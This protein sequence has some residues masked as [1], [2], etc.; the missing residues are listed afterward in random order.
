MKINTELT[1][2]RVYIR[3]Y[4]PADLDFAAGMWLDGENGRYLSDPA[5]DY[6]DEAF[7]KALDTLQ[8]S[9][10]GCYLTVCLN[11]TGERV[12]TCCL[13]PDECREGYDIGYCVHKSRWG[14][15]LAGE[16]VGL[17]VDEGILYKRRG[18]GM[19]VSKGAREKILSKRKAAFAENHVAPLLAEARSLGIPKEELLIMIGERTV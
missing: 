12:G 18:I 1:G 4:R 3:D 2:A 15:G 10:T 17:L 13:F 16:A 7:Q 6:V 11:G 5:R 9:E 19:F 8:D 14:Q